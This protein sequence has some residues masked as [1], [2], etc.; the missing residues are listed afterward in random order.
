MAFNL[1]G[2]LH[3][4]EQLYYAFKVAQWY[5][6]IISSHMRGWPPFHHRPKIN[7]LAAYYTIVLLFSVR[8]YFFLLIQI[9]V[10]SNA[11][12]TLMAWREISKHWQFLM[13]QLLARVHA[14]VCCDG[15]WRV[16]SRCCLS[17]P[18]ITNTDAFSSVFDMQT[19]PAAAMQHMCVVCVCVLCVWQ[20]SSRAVHVRAISK[21]QRYFSTPFIHFWWMRNCDVPASLC[22]R[23]SFCVPYVR[24]ACVNEA[25]ARVWA[26]VACQNA[27]R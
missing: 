25:V 2:Y 19:T 8:F 10:D 27:K 6:N 4:C 1:I 21:S 20:N 18:D 7:S 13:T 24:S 5:Y 11:F 17:T 23:R 12:D 14:R 16:G 9:E 26:K 22:S 3:A 15:L